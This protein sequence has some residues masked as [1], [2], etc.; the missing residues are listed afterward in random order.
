[1]FL[2]IIPGIWNTLFRKLILILAASP[3]YF[4][5]FTFCQFYTLATQWQ[6]LT[7]GCTGGMKVS[8]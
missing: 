8:R 7:Q 4:L 6:W 5:L 3:N 2:T 1:M